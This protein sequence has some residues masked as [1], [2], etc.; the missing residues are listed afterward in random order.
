[1]K[2]LERPLLKNKTSATGILLFIVLGVLPFAAA[3]IYA[4]LY[5]FG[6]VGVISSGFTTEF[7]VSVIKTGS[8]FKSLGYS[9]AIAG[10]AVFLSVVIALWLTL[11]FKSA[12]ENKFI[13]M[14]VYMPLAIPGLA[15]A[16]FIIQLLA[17]GGF[18]SR[19]SYASRLINESNEFP[20]LVNDN[21]ALGIILAFLTM[22]IPF[23]MLLFLNVYKNERVED[24]RILAYS[25]GA[26]SR[27]V[28]NKVV[29]PILLKKT[30]VLIALY[31]IFLLGSYEVPL[32]LGQES[33]QMISVLVI[34]ELKQYDLDKIPEGYVVAVMYTLVVAIAAI[35]LF[36]PRKREQYV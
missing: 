19:I 15:T 21:L 5:S 16:F 27:Q 3:F 17:K 25:L 23:F 8:F 24:L 36:L 1:M 4:L 12:L 2:I 33:P 34:Q 9:A 10:I 13:L 32:I 31:F 14:M 20:D 22:I 6:L 35:F 18:L 30:R 11:K 28:R 29:L 7:W 26:T